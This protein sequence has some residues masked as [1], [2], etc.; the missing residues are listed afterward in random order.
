[1]ALRHCTIRV[2]SDGSERERGKQMKRGETQAAGEFAV[3]HE[4]RDLCAEGGKRGEC[5]EETG[6]EKQSPER[7]EIGLRGD[8]GER[9]TDQQTTDG[10]RGECSPR[11]PRFVVK[12]D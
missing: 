4:R 5:A 7:R 9:E 11:Q 10:V 12:C 6:H 8:V 1:M 2:D 3:Q